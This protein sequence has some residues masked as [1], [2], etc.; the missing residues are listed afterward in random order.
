AR[1]QRWL[2][3]AALLGV[4]LIACLALHWFAL[5]NPSSR[6][7]PPENGAQWIAYPMPPWILGIVGKCERRGVFH[8]SVELASAPSSALLRVRAFKDCTVR[9]NNQAVELPGTA[10]WN[11]MRRC[12][13]GS[14]LHDGANDIHVVVTN[15]VGPPALWLSLDGPGF[16]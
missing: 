11:D 8:R 3:L 4:P 16:S 12:D 13:V 2:T 14:L 9:I 15:D 6:F 10:Q 5:R 7:L 1:T